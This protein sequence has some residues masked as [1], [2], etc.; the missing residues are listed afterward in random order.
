MSHASAVDGRA[1]A[2]HPVQRW[3]FAARG[4]AVTAGLALAV[5]AF[6]LAVERS[7]LDLPWPVGAAT[8]VVV[9][10]GGVLTLWW[11]ARA[12]RAWSYVIGDDVLELRHGVLT[13]TRSAIPYFRVQHVDITAGPVERA[14]GVAAL[15]VRTASATTD[16]RV[17]GVAA[18]EAEALR[19][20]ILARTGRGDA[21]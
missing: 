1:R 18:G 20:V 10:A 8:A 3:V 9:V 4:V 12:Y 15:V 6:E 14:L 17:P 11:S 2:L 7:E 21:V 16:A 5:L 19:E 13:S